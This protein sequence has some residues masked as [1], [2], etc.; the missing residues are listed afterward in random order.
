MK[1]KIEHL[2]TLTQNELYTYLIDTLTLIQVSSKFLIYS[3]GTT[4][5]KPML[6]VHLDTINTHKANLTGYKVTEDD[7]VTTNGL[8]ELS[9]TSSLSCLGGDDRAGVWVALELIKYM[10]ETGDYKYDIGFFLD[11]EIGCIGS[12]VFCYDRDK[13]TNNC[14]IGLDRRSTD[15]TDEV[16]VY[17]NDNQ[18][19]IDVFVNLGYKIEAGSITDASTLSNSIIPCVNLS[20]GYDYEH[21]KDEVLHIKC[22]DRTL[23]VLKD[24]NLVGKE[25]PTDSTPYYNYN[26]DDGVTH[27]YYDSDTMFELDTLKDYLISLGEDP[28]EVIELAYLKTGDDYVY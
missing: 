26:F 9:K 7:F 23:S 24:L 20:V 25:Y 4:E 5:S 2:L 19:L 1:M 14:Y 16:A 18:E 15:G 11:E 22:M 28:D 12:G 8:I 10:E 17:G 6:C 27:R 13:L 3:K 21:T